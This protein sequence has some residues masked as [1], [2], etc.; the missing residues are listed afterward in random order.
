MTQDQKRL[1]IAEAC[2]W[3]GISSLNTGY[4][5]WRKESY[6]QSIKA[7]S[8]ADLD[9]IPLD[10]LPD[11]FSDLNAMHEA[12]KVLNRYQ[13][14]VTYSDNLMRI[15]GYHTFDSAHATSAQR[16]EAFGLTLN[17]WTQAP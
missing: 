6:E 14:T 1:K 8:S 5:P 12:E 4:A 10:P 11:Y 16:A 13:Q 2:G 17:L 15:V 3:K 9:S 7:C